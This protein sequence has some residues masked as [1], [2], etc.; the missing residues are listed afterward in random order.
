MG[1]IFGWEGISRSELAA[2][3]KQIQDKW[4]L[5]PAFLKVPKILNMWLGGDFAKSKQI[6]NTWE[7]V[8]QFICIF[9]EVLNFFSCFIEMFLS[10]RSF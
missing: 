2:P 1:E 9:F 4:K 10:L 3:V 5:V 7:M 6:K 8:S